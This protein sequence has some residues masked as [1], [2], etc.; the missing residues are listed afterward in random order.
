MPVKYVILPDVIFLLVVKKTDIFFQFF[1][2]KGTQF[3]RNNDIWCQPLFYNQY[4]VA[5]LP[6]FEELWQSVF[7]YV[8]FLSIENLTQPMIIKKTQ[9]TNDILYIYNVVLYFKL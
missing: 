9:K 1:L 2:T 3:Y 5:I 4:D 6:L 8:G 7:K